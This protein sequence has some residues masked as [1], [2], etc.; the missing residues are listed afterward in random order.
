MVT[1]EFT[2]LKVY[3]HLKL[4]VDYTQKE[5]DNELKFAEDIGKYLT[6]IG[7]SKHEDDKSIRYTIKFSSFLSEGQMILSI[8]TIADKYNKQVTDDFLKENQWLVDYMDNKLW[9]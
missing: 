6:S 1:R 9:R 8:Y 7:A 4:G 2:F 5:L 3:P